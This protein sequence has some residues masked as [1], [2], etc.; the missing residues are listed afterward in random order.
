MCCPCVPNTV[1]RFL[2]TRRED[3]NEFEGLTKE[4]IVPYGYDSYEAYYT[5]LDT[6]IDK[7][8]DDHII[9]SA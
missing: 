8:V 5:M 1:E 6:L 4:N 9:T 3:V 2:C 7:Y